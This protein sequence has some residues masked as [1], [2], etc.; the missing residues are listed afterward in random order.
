MATC[1]G[2][3]PDSLEYPGLRKTWREL[4]ENDLRGEL[5]SITFHPHTHLNTSELMFNHYRNRC[6]ITCN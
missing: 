5:D 2:L 1:Q 4:R 3:L 6:P